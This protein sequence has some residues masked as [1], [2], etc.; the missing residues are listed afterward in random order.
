MQRNFLL[1]IFL[2]A[3]LAALQAQQPAAPAGGQTPPTPAPAQTSQPPSQTPAAPVRLA[4]IVV[5]DPAHGGTDNGARGSAGTV[6]KNIV[7]ELAKYARAEFERQGFHVIQTRQGDENPSYDDRAAVANAQR[8][9]IYISL[10]VSST[11]K[12]AT[13]RA[14]ACQFW[15]PFPVTAPNPGT[16]STS[17]QSR[18]LLLWEEAQR[19]FAEA[20]KRLA[21]MIQTELAKS[22]PGSPS[23]SSLAEVRSLR[24]VAAPA[25]AVEVS[26]VSSGNEQALEALGP[27]LAGALARGVSYYWQSSA[28]AGGPG[29]N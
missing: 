5:L 28:T 13:A 7:L 21:D 15:T 24:S 17:P 2:F 26:S 8:G 4:L 23:A 19:P 18:G 20:S 1:L 10:H 27:P 16:S 22:F 9:A 11:G 6:E 12:M 25:V 29:A 3:G 14:Y